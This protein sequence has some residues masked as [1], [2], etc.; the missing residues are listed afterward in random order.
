MINRQNELVTSAIHKLQALASPRLATAVLTL[1]LLPGFST[2][3]WARTDTYNDTI[4]TARTLLK[5]KKLKEA[6]LAA[7]GAISLDETR[8]E[9]HALAGMILASQEKNADAL[10]HLNRARECAPE[11]KKASLNKMISDVSSKVERET[12]SDT[13]LTAPKSA[14]MVLPEIQRKIDALQ[15]VAEEADQATG[16]ARKKLLQ[17]FIALSSEVMEH[18]SAD[19][20]ILLIRAAIALELNYQSLGC[21]V[22]NQ[23]ILIGA[24]QDEDP[25]MRKVLAQLERKKWIRQRGPL[26]AYYSSVEEMKARA[27][28]GDIEALFGVAQETESGGMGFKKDE[29]EGANLYRKAADAGSSVAMNNL[30]NKYRLGSGVVV[31][32]GEALK[33]FSRAAACGNRTAMINLGEMYEAGNGVEVNLEEAFTWYRKAAELGD[34]GAMC[35]VGVMYDFGRGVQNDYVEAVKWY[36]KAADLNDARA[37]NNLGAKFENGQGVPQNLGEALALYRKAADVGDLFAMNNIGRFYQNGIE[38]PVNYTE[39]E[40]WYRKSAES[41]LA[42]AMYNLGMLYRKGEGVA[43]NEAEGMKWIRQ[44]AEKGSVAA[45]EALKKMDG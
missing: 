37:I 10:I 40:K 11:S 23:L 19:R 17:E 4:T 24:E 21:D 45:K 30:G 34:P 38:V 39:A 2:T 1:A 5:D 13:D 16:D 44:A 43:K 36:R 33:L 6:F 18:C 32:Y 31:D 9:G 7:S 29:R 41:G 42:H 26:N 35:N 27:A 3:A 25:Q 28:A 15:I 14:K 8:W 20:N 22:S 12:K